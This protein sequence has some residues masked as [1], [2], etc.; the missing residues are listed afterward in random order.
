M[1]FNFVTKFIT[2]I[3][4]NNYGPRWLSDPPPPNPCLKTPKLDVQS[5]LWCTLSGEG[6]RYLV[7]RP[8]A[9]TNL[10]FNPLNRENLA[11]NVNKSGHMV[12]L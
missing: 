8:G 7:E 12:P 3:Q 2:R 5:K 1:Q 9:K 10:R 6:L 4:N 11:S